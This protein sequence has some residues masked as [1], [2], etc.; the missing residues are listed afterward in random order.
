MKHVA[1]R[2][3]FALLAAAALA[4]AETE[5]VAI[6]FLPANW[7]S[8]SM[9]KSL[10]ANG[11]FVMLSPN[12]PVRIVAAPERIA[13]ARTALSSLQT[14]PAIVALELSFVAFSDK[15]E[16]RPSAAPP[17]VIDGIP[18]PRHFT[19]PRIVARPGGGAI[20][21]PSQPIFSHR[22]AAVPA[23]GA[24]DGIPVTTRSS[25]ILRRV[26]AS[27]IL[28]QSVAVPLSPRAADPAALRGLAIKLDALPATEP[29]WTAASTELQVQTELKEGVL[30]V[31]VTPQL[32]LPATDG[33]E[34]RRIPLAACAAGIPISRGAA[35]PVGTLPRTDAEFYRLII[36]TA[37]TEAG[38]VTALRVTATVSYVGSPPP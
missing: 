27:C 30:V 23:A 38:A 20:A 16:T 5:D 31:N 8:A 3:A 21:V 11:R 6:G 32:V 7:V 24:G 28:G 19:P 2:V 33:G 35:A 22:A 29:E 14:S 37:P 36:G 18:A 4:R 10:G 9:A 34:A 1:P 12:G 17:E 26:N 13:A 15:V 25:R